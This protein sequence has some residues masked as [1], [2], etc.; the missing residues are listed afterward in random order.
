MKTVIQIIILSFAVFVFPHYIYAQ[1]SNQALKVL[2]KSQAT[3]EGKGKV[4]N[5]ES[6][7]IK[8]E[9]AY[10]KGRINAIE[11]GKF[12][13]GDFIKFVGIFVTIFLAVFG[14]AGVGYIRWV[15]E[16]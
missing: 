6:A 8:E 3:V 16:K 10:L 13:T 1:E 15:R 14:F 7:S 9:I 2:S 11:A 4:Y 5:D 12:G